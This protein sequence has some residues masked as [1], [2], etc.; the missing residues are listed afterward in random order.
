M[1]YKRAISA[2]LLCTTTVFSMP[3]LA[4]V[5]VVV[6]PNNTNAL[7]SAAIKRLFLGKEKKFPDGQ[8]ATPLNQVVDSAT[9]NQF[10]E[11]LLERNSSQIAAYWSKLVFTGKG[12]PPKEV[13]DDAAVVSVV[14]QDISAVGYV[15][16]SSVTTDVKVISLN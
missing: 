15:E 5:V 11:Q 8:P 1:S 9:R 3:I 12:V 6:H 10:D 16:R 13:N 2:I 14:S 7:D 4:E